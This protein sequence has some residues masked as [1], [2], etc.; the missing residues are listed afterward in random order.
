[1][2]VGRGTASDWKLKSYEFQKE[3]IVSICNYL[4]DSRMTA[5]YTRSINKSKFC[6]GGL[7]LLAFFG[8]GFQAYGYSSDFQFSIDNACKALLT[9]YIGI[10]G[11]SAKKIAGM[12][13]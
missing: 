3:M 4:K 8:L 12:T 5:L 7:A 2:V 9:Y 11:T 1:M 13:A 6:T 10:V